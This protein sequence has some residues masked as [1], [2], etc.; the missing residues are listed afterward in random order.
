MFQLYKSFNDGI[1]ILKEKY[2][3]LPE[4]NAVMDQAENYRKA[5]K[6]WNV[7]DSI[8]K[9][10]SFAITV[11]LWRIVWSVIVVIIYGVIC[12]P[13]IIINY[14][15]AMKIVSVSESKRRHQIT[16]YFGEHR[17]DILASYRSVIGLWS[18]PLITSIYSFILF[19]F[20]W[21]FY[22]GFFMSILYSVC[23]FFLWHIYCY[24]SLKMADKV[25]IRARII[26]YS[27]NCILF[28]QAV[29]DLCESRDALTTSVREMVDRYGPEVFGDE[30]AKSRVVLPYN[31][32][33][34]PT[35]SPKKTQ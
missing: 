26:K 19:V 22:F 13:N 25:L 21:I 32:D 2:G 16:K 5:I 12:A 24:F 34:S 29:T 18:F 1:R 8:I 6:T 20:L 23:F 9:H 11:L 30:F 3:D 14:L 33:Q 10:T 35:K 28:R 4:F 27:V 17:R 31:Y 7:S 15:Y